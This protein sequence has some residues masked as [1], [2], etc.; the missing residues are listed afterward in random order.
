MIYKNVAEIYQSLDKTR[1]KLIETIETVSA[2]KGAARENEAGWS[3]AEI[4][5]HIGIVES[6]IIRVIEK[7]LREVETDGEKSDGNFASP[8]SLVKHAEAA[9][10]QKFQAPERI[11][12]HGNQT[13]EESLAKLSE[14]KSTLRALQPRIEAVDATNTAFPHPAFGNLNLYEWLAFLGLHEARHLQ[15]IKRI[16]E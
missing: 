11:Q 7:L 5:E 12:P 6:G 4:V 16:L 15:Q 13:I 3:V 1:A 10:G 8:L 14:S 2:Q 9:K